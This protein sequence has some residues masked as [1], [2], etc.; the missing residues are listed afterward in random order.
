M[1]LDPFI[2]KTAGVTK[3]SKSMVLSLSMFKSAI[4]S[5]HFQILCTVSLSSPCKYSISLLVRSKNAGL[6]GSTGYSSRQFI[7]LAGEII[8]CILPMSFNFSP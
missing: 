7:F 6:L 2:G 3:R 1:I 8:M 5:L 4:L